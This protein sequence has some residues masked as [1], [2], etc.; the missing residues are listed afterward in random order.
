MNR[1]TERDEYGNADIIGIDSA[2]LQMNLDFDDFNKVTY[3]LNRLAAYE[4]T[5]L[6]PENI[7]YQTAQLHEWQKKCNLMHKDNAQL[8]AELEQVTE[9]YM[10]TEYV[11]GFMVMPPSYINGDWPDDKESRYDEAKKRYE[12]AVLEVRP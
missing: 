7:T 8:R 2:D 5:G 10:A 6:T 9:A 4:D 1:L 11:K 12:K 3:A